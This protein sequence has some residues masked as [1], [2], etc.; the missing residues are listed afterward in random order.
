LEVQ[1]HRKRNQLSVQG[2]ADVFFADKQ[3][4]LTATFRG[5]IGAKIRPASTS[6]M[7]FGLLNSIHPE[8]LA[9]KNVLADPV[10]RTDI[11]LFKLLMARMF[12]AASHIRMMAMLQEVMI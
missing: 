1:K 2:M 9:G 11:L 7:I 4:P 8:I 5:C 6:L 12:F 3:I 10:M